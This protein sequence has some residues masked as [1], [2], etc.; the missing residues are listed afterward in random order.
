MRNED[1]RQA[2]KNGLTTREYT[3]DEQKM[4]KDYLKSN[5]VYKCKDGESMHDKKD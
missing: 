2:H 1:D 4:I 5:K 3:A